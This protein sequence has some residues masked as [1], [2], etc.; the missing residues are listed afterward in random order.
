MV[1]GDRPVACAT[2]VIP[3][4]PSAIASLADQCRRTLSSKIGARSRYFSCTVVSV[5]LAFILPSYPSRLILTGY[6]GPA[7]NQG[8]NEH[9]RVSAQDAGQVRLH[10]VGAD[11]EHAVAGR[12]V[13]DAVGQGRLLS[14]R[15]QRR[16]RGAGE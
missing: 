10:V 3:P 15:Q 2:S 13:V 1:T 9:L 6:F 14:L 7:P 8:V 4:Q 16:A 11:D 12:S 5:V